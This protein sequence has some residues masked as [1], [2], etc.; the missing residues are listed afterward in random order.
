MMSIGRFVGM[1]LNTPAAGSKKKNQ[2]VPK[3]ELRGREAVEC[4]EGRNVRPN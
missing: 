4:M 3:P 2:S 1:Y